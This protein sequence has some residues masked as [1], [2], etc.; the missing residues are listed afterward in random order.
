[1]EG[2]SLS[3]FPHA[4]T[5]RRRPPAPPDPGP[6]RHTR[7]GMAQQGNPE[8]R[9]PDAAAERPIRDGFNKVSGTVLLGF[10]TPC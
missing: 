7:T 10:Q 9:E 4:P 1:M 6:P 2:C 5:T 3:A 8:T